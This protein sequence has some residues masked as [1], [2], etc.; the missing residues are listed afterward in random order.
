M[1]NGTHLIYHMFPTRYDD[2]FTEDGGGWEVM[3]IALQEVSYHM[4]PD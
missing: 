1:Y 3:C 2:M 4:P